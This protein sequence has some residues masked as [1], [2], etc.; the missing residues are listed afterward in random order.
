MSRRP[1]IGITSDVRVEKRT[2]SFVFAPYYECVERTGGLPL[3]IPA[4]SDPGLIPEVLAAVD[5]VLIVGGNDLDPR[6]YGEEPLATH[7]PVPDDRM[8]FDA[9][10]GRAVLASDLPVFGI[11]YGCQLLAVASGG[12]LV[13]HIPTQVPDALPHFGRYPDLPRHEVEVAPGSRLRELVGPQLVVNSGHH[14]D[15]RDLGDGLAITARAP[16]GVIEALEAPGDRFVLGVQW[17]PELLG[18]RPEQLR[19]FQALTRA[20]SKARTG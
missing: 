17:H 1:V 18:E 14:Q 13:Q 8:G 2:L 16:D 11:C 5:G 20:A 9:E 15:P 7:D 19:L 4:L 12:T 6:L 10:L 3:Q